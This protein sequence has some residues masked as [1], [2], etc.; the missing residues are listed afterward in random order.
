[1]MLC[2]FDVCMVQEIT[3]IYEAVPSDRYLRKLSNPSSET[4]QSNSIENG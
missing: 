1:M 4:M 2:G 3:D